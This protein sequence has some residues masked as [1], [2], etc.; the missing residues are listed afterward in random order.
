ML[1]P[2]EVR[3]LKQSQALLLLS[4][5]DPVLDNKYDIHRHPNVRLTPDGGGKP[6]SM[7][8]DYMDMAVSVSAAELKTLEPEKVPPEL[9]QQFELIE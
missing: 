4:A 8:C 6:Y 5:E 7:P 3:R 1:T 9:L 2:D